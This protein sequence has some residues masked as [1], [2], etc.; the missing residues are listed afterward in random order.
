MQVRSNAKAF[1]LLPTFT[2]LRT[3]FTRFGRVFYWEITPKKFY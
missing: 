1:Y 2:R 3:N